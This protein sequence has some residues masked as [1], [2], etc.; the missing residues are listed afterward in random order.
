MLLA[1]Q[2]DWVDGNRS[3][4]GLYLYSE[5][6]NRY[7]G[8]SWI[9]IFIEH[10]EI[11]LLKTCYKTY[12]RIHFFIGDYVNNRKEGNGIFWWTTGSHAGDRYEGEFIGDKRWKKKQSYCVII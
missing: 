6:G 11:L 3:G 9:Y 2:G 10:V 12:C 4:K 5:T 7:K 8:I 1:I